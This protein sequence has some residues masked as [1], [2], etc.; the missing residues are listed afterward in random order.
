[1]NTFKSE[2]MKKISIYTL[3]SE[4]APVITSKQINHTEDG[5]TETIQL[6]K[7][8]APGIYQPEVTKPDGNKVKMNVIY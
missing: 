2:A 3:P 8:S 6:D 4:T 7:Y 1:M 5:I